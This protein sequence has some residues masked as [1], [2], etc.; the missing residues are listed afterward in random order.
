MY[1]R[2]VEG[3]VLMF[4]V[5]GTL[6]QDNL[7]LYDDQTHSLWIQ[8]TGEAGKGPLKGKQLREIDSVVTDWANWSRHH[9]SGTAVS[10]KRGLPFYTH[11]FYQRPGDFEVIADF[12]KQVKTWRLDELAARPVRN[13]EIDSQPILV[14][15]DTKSFTA[16]VFS[17]RL[18]SR[19]LTF[20]MSGDRLLDLE[21]KSI[22]D[23]Y[24]GQALSGPLAGTQL[25]VLH[26][27]TGYRNDWRKFR[28]Q[29]K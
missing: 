14:A 11:D 26:S 27:R 15:Y 29:G 3:K 13:E 7:V 4:G 22:W 2:T 25:T 28:P 19:L 24:S 10:I 23:S 16:R 5:E 6:H 12:G 1:D 20:Q 9:A 8:Y 21:T 17:R 18:P